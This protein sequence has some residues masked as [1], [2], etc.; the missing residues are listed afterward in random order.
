MKI[1]IVGGTGMIGGHAALR[2]HAKGHEVTI[3]GRNEAAP[4]SALAKLPFLRIDFTADE[5]PANLLGQFEALVFAAGNDIRHLPKGEDFDAYVTRVNAACAP[6]FCRAARDAGVRRFIN[7]GSFYPQAAP[8]LLAGNAYMRS[9]QAADAAIRALAGDDFFAVSINAPF[10]IGAV[11]GLTTMFRS[12]VGFA[13]GKFAPMPQAV[14]PGGVNF[15]STDSLSD[16]IEAVLVGGRNG[17]AYLV[18]DENLSFQEYFGAFFEALGKPAPLVVDAEFPL[19]PDAAISWG[20]GNN[21][22]YEPDE[23]E[24][25]ELGYRRNDVRRTIREEIVPQFRDMAR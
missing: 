13:E 24:A 12:Y 11:P 18:G 20:R 5:Q 8:H 21:L 3:A 22:Y 2:L 1:L 15:I 14:P 25:A 4:G 17:H 9:R 19:L 23:G 16:A 7:I 10:V 6:R